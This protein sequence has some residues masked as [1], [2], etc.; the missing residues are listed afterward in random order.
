MIITTT[1]DLEEVGNCDCSCALPTCAAPRKECESITIDFDCFYILP[2]VE[3]VEPAEITCRRFAKKTTSYTYTSSQTDNPEPG[4]S[5]SR[6]EINTVVYEQNNDVVPCVEYG[7]TVTFSID[8]TTN[9]P[10]TGTDT[11]Y[12]AASESIRGGACAGSYTYTDNNDA[13]N[14][15]SGAFTECGAVVF[16]VTD[17]FARTG[18]S[19][20]LF[21]TAG[22]ITTN[23]QTSFEDEIDVAFV[24]AK[25]ES[26]TFPDDANGESCNALMES[27]T[28]CPETIQ[29]A[30]KT[31]MR[32]APPV[33]FSTGEAPRTTYEAQWDEVFFPTGYDGMIDDPEITPPDPLPDGW[34][35]P[36]IPTPGRPNP[37]LVASRSWIWD[38]NMES[39]WSA[40]FEIPIP[41]SAGETRVV[42]L[43]VLCYRSARLGQKPTAHGEV[44]AI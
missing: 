40:W 4:D 36:Q 42:N 38:G 9:Q 26:L 19:F 44:Y 16:S 15:D 22:D 1:Q 29:S 23:Y 11:I 18:D 24:T 37:S 28:G 2:E 20:S 14:N 7:E 21:Y 32:F 35:H 31:R 6:T 8:E 43:M 27:V 25:L 33:G 12:H 17:D 39:P 5:Y 34:E 30:T 41:E 10:S 3:T 13:G